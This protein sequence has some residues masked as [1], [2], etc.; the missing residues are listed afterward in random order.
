MSVVP[1]MSMHVHTYVCNA[2][3]S[4][5][6]PCS[7]LFLLVGSMTLTL[8]L[9]FVT[10]F[11][12]YYILEPRGFGRG[13]KASLLVFDGHKSRW[14]YAA[15]MFLI[16]NNCWPFCEPS[17]TSRWAQVGDNAAN[18]MIVAGMSHFY[19]VWCNK[20]DGLRTFTRNDYNWCYLTGSMK[21]C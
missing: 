8:F 10:W 16:A 5:I 19:G 9:K 18:A 1:D 7:T 13:K 6:T 21:E 12:K 14:D 2:H 20:F 17:R 15:I 3:K 11:V 4:I